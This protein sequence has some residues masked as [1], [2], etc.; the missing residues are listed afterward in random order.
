[1]IKEMVR[2]SLFKRLSINRQFLV[3]VRSIFFSLWIF[4]HD[5]SQITGLQGKG[6]GIS[7]TSHYH[8]QPFHRHL[9]ISRAINVER[10]TLHIPG[11]WT[12]TNNPWFPSASR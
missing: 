12:R 8:F 9:E 6:V 3:E 2:P 1:M 5:H 4:F 7:L 10:L 11:D